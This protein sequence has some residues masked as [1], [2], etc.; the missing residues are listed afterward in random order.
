MA[1]ITIPGDPANFPAI[2]GSV[3]TWGPV[4]P[5]TAPVDA[6]FAWINQGGA[7]ITDMGGS[8]ALAVPANSGDSLRIRKKAAPGTPYTIEIAFVWP[9]HLTDFMNAGFVW[10]QSSDGKLATFAVNSTAALHQFV[11]HKWTN[12]TTSS[13]SYT[14]VTIRA[15]FGV[16]FLKAEDT[17]ANRICSYSADGQNYTQL[18]SVSRTDFLTADEVGFYLNMN[19]A[20]HASVMTLL[21]WKQS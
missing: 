10:R 14:T 11:S 15:G 20:T 1:R 6:D 12:A 13:A 9:S 16:Y 7:S 4:F 8:L 3:K 2:I 17:G 21:S 18:H 5:L 19:N